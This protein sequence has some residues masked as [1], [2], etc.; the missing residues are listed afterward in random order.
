MFNVTTPVFVEADELAYHLI[1]AADD[2]E[3]VFDLIVSL[4]ANVA[5]WEFTERVYQYFKPLHKE[6]KAHV[7][8]DNL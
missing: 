6:Y 7:K 4:E 2:Q 5:D 1:A 3:D 8:E